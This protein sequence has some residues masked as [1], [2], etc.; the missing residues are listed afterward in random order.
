LH[1]LAVPQKFSNSGHLIPDEAG[2]GQGSSA[3]RASSPDTSIFG[4]QWLTE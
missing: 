3:L 4:G 1:S 2:T